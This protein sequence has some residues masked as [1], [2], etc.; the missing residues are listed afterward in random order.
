MVSDLVDY[1]VSN[2]DVKFSM[3]W[4]A[5]ISLVYRQ[6]IIFSRDEFILGNYNLKCN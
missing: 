2:R 6:M 5:C 3:I 1:A 4:V